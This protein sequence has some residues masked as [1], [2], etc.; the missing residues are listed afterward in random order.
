MKSLSYGVCKYSGGCCC[1]FFDHDLEGNDN[2]FIQGSAGCLPPSEL[3]SETAPDLDNEFNV[4][5]DW[6]LYNKAILKT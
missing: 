5:K 1:H 3:K 6:K 2:K 4:L